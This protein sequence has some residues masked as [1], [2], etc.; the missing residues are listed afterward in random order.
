V[1]AYY[2]NHIKYINM[3]CKQTEEFVNVKTHG[4]FTYHRNLN[5]NSLSVSLVEILGCCLTK[6]TTLKQCENCIFTKSVSFEMFGFDI[7]GVDF[8][9]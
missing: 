7:K 3:L 8:Y 6:D 9:M 1:A 5:I 4:T 2:H